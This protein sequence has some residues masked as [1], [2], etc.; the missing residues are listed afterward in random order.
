MFRIC[1]FLLI[2]V[3][4]AGAAAR[5]VKLSS[6]N[7]G[8]CPDSIADDREPARASVRK[9]SPARETK[10]KPTVSGDAVGNGRLQSPRWNS[11]LPGMF[12]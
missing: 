4:S 1:L 9:S 11:F 5:D 2:A 12:R 8:S 3:A 10:A 7:G 6:A